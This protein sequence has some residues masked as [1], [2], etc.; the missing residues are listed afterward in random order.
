M[1]EAIAEQVQRWLD[2]DL[3][4]VA[5]R[6]DDGD[7]GTIPAIRPCMHVMNTAYAVAGGR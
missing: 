6:I 7:F 1:D 4:R 5:G 2:D 3:Q